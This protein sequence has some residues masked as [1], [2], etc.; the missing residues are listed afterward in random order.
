MGLYVWLGHGTDGK[1]IEIAQR[2]EHGL[3]G[4]LQ[5]PEA[6][7]LVAVAGRVL[8]VVCE[9]CVDL[10]GCG[11]EQP[12]VLPRRQIGLRGASRTHAVQLP[13]HA[14]SGRSTRHLIG[15]SV[16]LRHQRYSIRS[17][18]TSH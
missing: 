13:F 5:R 9:R 4:E 2:I 12:D 17:W 16:R 15:T 6:D 11:I 14:S 3:R 18:R 7:V 1:V 8:H 10:F